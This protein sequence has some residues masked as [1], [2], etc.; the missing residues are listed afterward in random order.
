MRESLIVKKITFLGVTA[1]ISH[2]NRAYVTHISVTLKQILGVNYCHNIS[3][4]Q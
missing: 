3:S 1:T 2:S 4:H